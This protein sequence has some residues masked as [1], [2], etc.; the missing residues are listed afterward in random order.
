M[1][2]THLKRGDDDAAMALYR[3]MLRVERS[4]MG[5][6]VAMALRHIGHVHHRRGELQQALVHY[7]EVLE[8]ERR[9]A[10]A[11]DAKVQRHGWK[12]DEYAVATESFLAVARSLNRIGNIHLQKGH[13]SNMMTC[14][15]E[16]MR[17]FAKVAAPS[18]NLHG[19]QP[20]SS[21]DQNHPSPPG[22]TGE[23]NELDITG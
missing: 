3:E 2:M 15:A 20:S 4:A 18:P 1:A 22:E 19:Q 13:V 21:S 14:F 23:S 5:P 10:A 16:A 11:E 7:E 8:I 17:L 9:V 12:G 6:D